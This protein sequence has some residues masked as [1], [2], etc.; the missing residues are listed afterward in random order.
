[1]L[2]NVPDAYQEQERRVSVPLSTID[3]IF[4]VFFRASEKEQ[5]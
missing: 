2:A 1:M 4:L 3:I 5:A